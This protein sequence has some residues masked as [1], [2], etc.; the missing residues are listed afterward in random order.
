[1]YI[2]ASKELLELQSTTTIEGQPF[3]VERESTYEE[4][5][6]LYGQARGNWTKFHFYALE[7]RNS[8]DEPA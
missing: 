2:V 4:W 3:R 1:M 5:M 7:Q 6:G 8:T